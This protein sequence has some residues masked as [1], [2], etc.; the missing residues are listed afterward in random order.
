MII[1]I[2]IND[3][4]IYNTEKQEIKNVKKALK[5]KFYMSNLRSLLF[6]LGIVEIQDCAN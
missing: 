3:L 1:N 2:Y 4:F 6:Y 5:A